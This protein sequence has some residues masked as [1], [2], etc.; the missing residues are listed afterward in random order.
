MPN[1]VKVSRDSE[2]EGF[3]ISNNL[4]WIPVGVET[5]LGFDHVFITIVISREPCVENM[6]GCSFA[7]QTAF[8]LYWD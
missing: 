2:F 7:S 6:H 8:L 3:Y 5:S 1:N 4:C